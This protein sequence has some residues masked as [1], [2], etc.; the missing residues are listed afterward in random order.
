MPLIADLQSLQESSPATISVKENTKDNKCK[1]VRPNVKR[2]L[3][4]VNHV[5][6]PK[7]NLPNEAS[8]ISDI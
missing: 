8:F 2:L 5:F 6:N 7:D 3:K 4:E 1:D